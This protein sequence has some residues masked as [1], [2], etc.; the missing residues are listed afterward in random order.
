MR[1]A[2]AGTPPRPRSRSA[3]ARRRTRC[4]A[5]GPAVSSARS[6]RA[7]P[8]SPQRERSLSWPVSI[9]SPPSSTTWPSAKWPRRLSMRP[10]DAV[11]RLEH[12]HGHAGLVQPPGGGEARDARAHD[13]HRLRGG[14]RGAERRVAHAPRATP[15]AAAAEACRNAR[16]WPPLR[17][18]AARPPPDPGPRA[19][20]A[21]RAAATGARARTTVCGAPEAS[22]P[23]RNGRECSHI[24]RRAGASVPATV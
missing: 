10:T 6:S 12:A 11:L 14:S 20:R 9:S 2:R 15:A 18:S 19:A 4:R 13:H 24:P 21:G 1:A 3:A 22:L 16:R 23:G 17:A 5:R 8:S 7:R